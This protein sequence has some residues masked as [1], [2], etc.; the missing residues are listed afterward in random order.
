MIAEQYEFKTTR[1][2]TQFGIHADFKTTQRD[3]EQ[4]KPGSVDLSTPEWW[5][6]KDSSHQQTQNHLEGG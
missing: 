6:T 2:L 4:V 5:R 3:G 1:W